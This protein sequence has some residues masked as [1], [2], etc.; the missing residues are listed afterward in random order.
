MGGVAGL[1][2]HAPV[3]GEPAQLAVEVA[4]ARRGAP[5]RVGVVGGA[6]SSISRA[7]RARLIS[8]A[9][10]QR[11]LAPSATVMRRWCDSIARSSDIDDLLNGDIAAFDPRHQIVGELGRRGDAAVAEQLDDQLADQRVVGLADLDM[12]GRGEARA[13]V[14]QRDLPQRRRRVGDDQQRPAPRL[15]LVPG[16]EERLLVMLLGIVEQPAAGLADEDPAEQAAARLARTGEQG[17]HDR[18][19]RP[20]LR[21]ARRRRGWR[22][23]CRKSSSLSATG[24]SSGS[25]IWFI[26]VAAHARYPQRVA[27]SL[28][29]SSPAP[30]SAAC[31]AAASPTIGDPHHRGAAEREAGGDRRGDAADPAHRQ[32]GA[33]D[34]AGVGRVDLDAEGGGRAGRHRPAGVARSASGSSASSSSSWRRRRLDDDERR[35]GPRAGPASSAR[36]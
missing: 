28:R 1:L 19:E 12:R 21:D 25:A 20:A 11:P 22:R 10:V 18:P 5:A 2:E 8:P 15:G 31:S 14:G 3:E 36:A 32:L 24:Q 29:P 34:R 23:R 17:R 27:A 9:S 6:G 4:R 33:A 26:S 16:V 30:A 13:Q 7:F 35:I